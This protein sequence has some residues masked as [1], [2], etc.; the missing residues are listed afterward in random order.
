MN[1]ANE[2]ALKLAREAEPET[3][4]R[5]RAWTVRDVDGCPSLINLS[6]IGEGNVAASVIWFDRFRLADLDMV[7]GHMNSEAGVSDIMVA[8]LISQ[9]E[10]KAAMTSVLQSE[11][12]TRDG[13]LSVS[14]H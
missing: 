3:R 1:D 2:T 9:Y 7:A 12:S 10:S 4:G 14:T 8:A 11:L 13:R 6:F 5:L